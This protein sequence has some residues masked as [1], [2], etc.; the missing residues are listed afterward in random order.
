MR[1]DEQALAFRKWHR[2][3][4]GC[5]DGLP[6]NIPGDDDPPAPLDVPR[7]KNQVVMLTVPLRRPG[8]DGQIQD[9]R[10]AWR[11]SW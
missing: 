6:F 8:V 10:K 3:S 7:C 5:P 4:V 2:G 11:A 9:K 1:L